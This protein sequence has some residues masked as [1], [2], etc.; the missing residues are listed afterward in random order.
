MPLYEYKCSGCGYRF[1]ELGSV[2]D[3]TEKI[4]CRRCGKEAVRQMSASALVVAGGSSNE[5]TDM[6]IGREANR[7]WQN[8]HDRQNRR[9]GNQ[10]LRKVVSPKGS[11]GKYMPL[12]GLGDS[13]EISH[14]KDYVEALQ[15]HRKQR[16][17]KGVA[18]FN[19]KGTF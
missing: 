11:D 15:T 17:E 3:L 10:S 19:D 5:T 4:V 16:R 7:R 13:G 8:Y 9:R 1:E 18:Q 6:R 12:M 2:K 14:R